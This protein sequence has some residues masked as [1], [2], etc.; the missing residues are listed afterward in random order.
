MNS[1][2]L[3]IDDDRSMC[4]TLSSELEDEGYECAWTTS[5][6]EA[7]ELALAQDF[8]AVI[9]DLKM[10]G[11]NGVDF[12]S[13]MALNRPN[14]P[15]IVIT[16]FGSLETAVAAIRAGAYDFITKP[17]ET[18]TVVLALERAMRFRR[19]GE[20]L[21]R[22]RE[23]V[24]NVEGFEEIQGSSEPMRR[25]FALLDKI[26]GTDTAVLITGETGAGKELVARGLHARS[27]RAARPFVAVN[28][29]AM[30]PQLLESE[31]FGHARGAFTDAKTAHSGLFVQSD[32]GTLLL[33]E[34]GELPLE[35]QPKLLR[36]LEERR[37]RPVGASAEVAVDARIIVATNRDLEQSVEEGRFREDLLYRINVIQ[38]RV[39]PL[40]ERGNDVLLLAQQ[41]IEGYASRL[42]RPVKGLTGAAA[43]KLLGYAWPGNVR[44]LRNCIERAVTLTDHEKIVVEDLPERIR[45]YRTTD[46]MLESSDAATL[47]P[48]E[49]VERRYVEKVM[50]E[51]GGN[52]AQAARILGYDRKRL[53]RK[54]K[55]YGIS[56]DEP[57]S[58]QT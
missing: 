56:A 22:L 7:L 33:D 28:C 36:A 38:V 49:E 35:L 20:E 52:K 29:A 31:L 10:Q 13:R 4:E 47:P 17:L 34:I 16:A 42:G 54:L 53:Y 57:S 15:V 21:S 19:L 45:N 5:S 25:L 55:R 2:L 18:E 30:P 3:I 46:L 40:R 39:P 8:D 43:D 24:R 11:L 41:F 6:E 14:L 26:A 32:G 44:E 58:T 9:T 51:V 37:I 48:M 12:C 50:R 23:A 1:R 27:R